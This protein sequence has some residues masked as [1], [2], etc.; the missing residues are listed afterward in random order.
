[1][2]TVRTSVRAADDVGHITTEKECTMNSSQL[3]VA[4]L[5]AAPSLSVGVAAAPAATP[6][7]A[8]WYVRSPGGKK[9]EDDG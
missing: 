2:T 4:A 1:V 3:I 6:F 5:A 8:G 9:V 7:G